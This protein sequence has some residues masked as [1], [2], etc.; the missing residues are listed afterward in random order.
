M[1]KASEHNIWIIIVIVICLIVALILVVMVNNTVNKTKESTDGPIKEGGN[2]LKIEMCKRACDSCQRAHGEG[3]CK[4]WND[5]IGK[6][7]EDEVDI[8]CPY[9]DE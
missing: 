8:S 6:G 3:N 5:E 9:D 2:T 7:C 4:G 1:R